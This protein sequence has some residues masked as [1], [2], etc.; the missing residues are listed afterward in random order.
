MQRRKIP[1]WALAAL[2]IT[3]LIVI[4][5]PGLR[6]TGVLHPEPRSVPTVS[7][8]AA[9]QAFAGAA[10]KARQLALE[11]LIERNLPGLSLAVGVRGGLVWAEGVGLADLRTNTP[12][13][14]EHRFPIGTAS[15]VLASAAAGL[16]LEA[17]RL[18][19]DD[20]I[21]THVPT[22]PARHAVTIRQLMSH[23][24]GLDSDGGDDSELFIRHCE[25]PAQAFPY[26]A[27]GPLLFP[28]GSSFSYSNYSWI[29]VSAAI[30]AAAGKPFLVY[31]QERVLDPLNLRDTVPDPTP[32]EP[33]DDHPLAN[34][35]RELIIDP[36]ASRGAAAPPASPGGRVT[37]YFPRFAADPKFGLHLLRPLDHS[38]YSG[39]GVYLSTPSDLVRFGLA[40]LGGKLLKPE[41]VALLQTPHR[42]PSGDETGYALGWDL[43][44]ITL[45]GKPVRAVG[46]DGDTLGGMVASL[47][48]VPERGLVV[49]VVS[50]ISYAATFDLASKV[51]GAFAD[52]PGDK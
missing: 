47:L 15:T 38:C 37:S 27:E 29:P 31:V 22:F 8:A 50:N 2:G 13:T 24:S 33:D 51:A 41:T 9:P 21:Q 11:H 34:L 6:V 25:S 20:A 19:L 23:T 49:A 26:F 43:E 5:L 18:N 40:I 42:L 16:L 39:A 3:G 30:E 17:G 36:R 7:R 10:G 35:V 4:L 12:V 48:M 44:T 1:L 52:Q 14:P 32:F 45:A 46:H 28:P